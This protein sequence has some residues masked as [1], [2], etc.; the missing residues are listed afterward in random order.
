MRICRKSS[1]TLACACALVFAE[2]THAQMPALPEP[3]AKTP[4]TIRVPLNTRQRAKFDIRAEKLH[5]V[6]LRKPRLRGSMVQAQDLTIS[7]VLVN[8]G[9]D[10][11]A[12]A[13]NQVD[14]SIIEGHFDYRQRV[15]IDRR[16]VPYYPARGIFDIVI[17]AKD[18]IELPI[19]I[20]GQKTQRVG[21]RHRPSR[22]PG[23]GV[24]GS[25]PGTQN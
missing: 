5:N 24:C 25:N 14:A 1:W 20:R 18:S 3:R 21:Y 9:S 11:F 6:A 19:V 2:S 10:T 7:V 4:G 15:S 8:D 22:G 12:F 23:C 13:G 17:R 16:R